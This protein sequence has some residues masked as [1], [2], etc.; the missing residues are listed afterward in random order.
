MSWETTDI[1]RIHLVGVCGMGMSGLAGLLK[2][3][4][5]DV[6]GSDQNFEPPMGQLVKS[7]GIKLFEGYKAENISN[8]IKLAVIGNVASKNHVEAQE[9][10]RQNIPYSSFPETLYRIFLERCSK[11]AVIAGT[12][13]KT[14]TSA[15][16]SWILERAGFEPTYLFGGILANT[17]KSYRL[18]KGK[19]CVVEGDEYDSAFFDKRPK[20]LHYY[21]TLLVITSLEFDHADIYADLDALKRAFLELINSLEYGTVVLWN[22][23]YAALREVMQSANARINSIPL[24]VEDTLQI[25]KSHEPGSFLITRGCVEITRGKTHLIGSHNLENILFAF[26][27]ARFLGIDVESCISAIAEF[28]GVKKRQE[29]LGEIGGITIIDD[30]AHHPTAVE[31]TIEAVRERYGKRRIIAVFEPRSNTSRTRLFE[32]EF[33]QALSGA[34]VT[35]IAP[36]DRPERVAPENRLRPDVVCEFI[37]S[38]GKLAIATETPAQILEELSRILE[39]NDIVLFMS[40]GPFHH[41]PMRTIKLLE[42]RKNNIANDKSAI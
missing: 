38:K 15:L 16:L 17:Q 39:P 22:P 9:I 40:N 35:I 18:G 7:L 29:I 25:Q 41:I 14:T 11:R 13:G 24:F 19:C 4:G 8:E 30:F 37:R 2:E 32:R 21:P 27:A 3:D 33:A 31:K 26:A 42:S 1:K 20:F 34:D 12:H 28:K 10:I 5:F 36:I 6:S 23:R